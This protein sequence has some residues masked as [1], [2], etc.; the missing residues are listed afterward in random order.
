MARSRRYSALSKALHLLLAVAVLHQLVISQFMSAPRP[1]RAEDPL[2]ELHEIVGLAAL[3][4]LVFFWLWAFVRRG[5]TRLRRLFPWFS[6]AA[7]RD[8]RL[9]A[10]HHLRAVRS[11]RLPLNEDGALASATHGLGLL[12]ASVMALTGAFGYLVPSARSLLGIHEAV[13]PLM[14]L[15]LVAHSGMAVLHEL[16]GHKL[17]RTMFGFRVK[18]PSQ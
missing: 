13:A 1:G 11:R 9:D 12:I 15:Y 3:T 14:W 16:A 8:L 4:I 17:L 6:A 2:F 18:S 5:E 7:L 10:R